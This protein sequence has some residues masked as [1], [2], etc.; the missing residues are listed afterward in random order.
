MIVIKEFFLELEILVIDEG[1]LD[2][3]F[4]QELGFEE[5]CYELEQICL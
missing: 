2:G 1:V 4:K 5:F 3:Y